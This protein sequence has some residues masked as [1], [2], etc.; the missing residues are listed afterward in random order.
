MEVQFPKKLVLPLIV[1]LGAVVGVFFYLLYVARM[2]SYLSDD[3]SACVN[4]HIMAPYYQSWQKSS[5]QAWTTCNE[6]HVP[7]DNFVRGYAF[8]AKDGLYHAA[9]FT[10]RMEP[11]VIRPRDESYG[12]IMENCIRCHTQLNQEFV[13]TGMLSYADTQKGMGKACW[14]CHREVPHGRISNLAMSPNAIVP[15][16]ESPVPQ[17]LKEIMK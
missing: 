15:L 4:C 9:V 8:K 16:P 17:W 2:P 5:H 6:C 7:Q 12:V 3:P 11:Q 10:A 14:D 1:L 13:N